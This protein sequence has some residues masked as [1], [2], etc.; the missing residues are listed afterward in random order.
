MK[1]YIVYNEGKKTNKVSAGEQT[2]AVKQENHF[3]RQAFVLL[4]NFANVFK[5]IYFP[6]KQNQRGIMS[7]SNK[8]MTTYVDF[9]EL[10]IAF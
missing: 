2:A 3:Y 9:T 5:F 7:N 8:T 1:D 4:L 10:E 6:A